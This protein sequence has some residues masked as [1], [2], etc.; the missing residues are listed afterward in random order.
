MKIQ[1]LITLIFVS[2]ITLAQSIKLTDN[3]IYPRLDSSYWNKDYEILNQ[4]RSKIAE[5]CQ[6]CVFQQT[7]TTRGRFCFN[8]SMGQVQMDTS[9]HNFSNEKLIGNW[10]VINYGLFEVVDSILPNSKIIYRTETVLVEQNKDNGKVTFTDSK[11]KTE[12]KNIKEI[13]NKNKKYK[14]ESGKFL[15]IKSMSGYCGATIIGLTKEGFLIMDDHT[16][17]TLSKR[18]KYM[19]IKTTIRRLILKKS[20]TA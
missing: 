9:L 17:R 7:D 2:T 15:T 11:I 19:V 20:I 16:F 14:I 13:P 10:D 4:N 6:T 18:G 1:Y 8:T 12:L 5:R 3:L